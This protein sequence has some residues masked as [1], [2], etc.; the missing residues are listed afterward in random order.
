MIPDE[1]AIESATLNNVNNSV[2][3]DVSDSSGLLPP[4]LPL[5][6]ETS[7]EVIA[8]RSPRMSTTSVQWDLRWREAI[9][10]KWTS[11]G[12][13]WNPLGHVRRIVDTILEDLET[14][15]ESIYNAFGDSP[16][17]QHEAEYLWSGRLIAVTKVVLSELFPVVANWYSLRYQVDDMLYVS[18]IQDATRISAEQG[19][20][21]DLV[22]DNISQTKIGDDRPSSSSSSTSISSPTFGKQQQQQEYQT[23]DGKAMLCE[24]KRLISDF[25]ETGEPPELLSKNQLFEKATKLNQ[26]AHFGKESMSIIDLTNMVDKIWDYSQNLDSGPRVVCHNMFDEEKKGQDNSTIPKSSEAS[27]GTKNNLFDQSNCSATQMRLVQKTRETSDGPL[28]LNEKQRLVLFTNLDIP[29][30]AGSYTRTLAL[31]NQLP[32]D[33]AF[34]FDPTTAITE[35]IM[36][37]RTQM[38]LEAE[39]TYYSKNLFVY[40]RSKLYLRIRQD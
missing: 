31:L 24:E 5:N 34:P 16:E 38:K 33:E 3:H 6:K 39:A 13:Q 15:R 1:V 30:L 22:S 17:G 20:A 36:E 32:P 29:H 10:N 11:D 19:H 37:V 28:A 2:Q 8:I 9:S 25:V 18:A 35:K 4:K 12:P 26:W 27:C 40:T 21:I 14:K 23:K 7:P